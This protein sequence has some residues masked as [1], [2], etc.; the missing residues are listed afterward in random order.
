MLK[1]RR[2]KPPF[3]SLTPITLSLILFLRLYMISRAHVKRLSGQNRN[4][5]WNDNKLIER[6]TFITFFIMTIC[7]TLCTVPNVFSNTYRNINGEDIN[8]CFVCFAQLLY[9]ANTIINVV[10]Y[11][12]RTVAFRETFKTLI[13]NH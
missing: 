7:V 6:K 5:T 8:Y 13:S 10:V 2:W 4:T 3:I 12:W 11:Y 9:L 1:W